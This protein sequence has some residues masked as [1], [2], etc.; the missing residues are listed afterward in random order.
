[1]PH[2]QNNHYTNRNQRPYSKINPHDPQYL[3]HKTNR[4]FE[5]KRRSEDNLQFNYKSGNKRNRASP[6][7]NHSFQHNFDSGKTNCNTPSCFALRE[8]SD[9]ISKGLK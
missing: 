9:N 3:S 4:N 5:T 1:M 7:I 8:E 2:S 6:K